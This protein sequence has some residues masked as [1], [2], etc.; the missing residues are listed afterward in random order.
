MQKQM[1]IVLAMHGIPPADFPRPELEEFLALHARFKRADKVDRQGYEHYEELE[2]KLRYWPRTEETDPY[3]A[4]ALGL[5]QALSRA[6]GCEVFLG[7]DE[8]C[9]PSL[10]EAL[11][12]ASASEAHSVLVVTPAM[13]QGSEDS[14]GNIPAA[15]SRARERH[16]GRRIVYAWPFPVDEVAAFLAGQAVQFLTP[17]YT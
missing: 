7:F 10:D 13:T 8:F 15:I 1:V 17:D 14:E 9:A 11:D 6:A 4:A 5:V 2:A 12:R 3:H 16:P